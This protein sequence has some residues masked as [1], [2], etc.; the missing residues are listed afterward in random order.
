[1]GGPGIHVGRSLFSVSDGVSVG[2]TVM[3]VGVYDVFGISNSFSLLPPSVGS[4]VLLQLLLWLLFGH[5]GQTGS[6]GVTV[7][8]SSDAVVAIVTLQR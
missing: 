1:M 5:G 2:H 7:V 3:V 4:S 8:G 6:V